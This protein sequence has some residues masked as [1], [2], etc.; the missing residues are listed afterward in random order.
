ML[1]PPPSLC[2]KETAFLHNAYVP[3][4]REG[5]CSQI[6]KLSLRIFEKFMGLQEQGTLP[7]PDTMQN[8]EAQENPSLLLLLTWDRH[9]FKPPFLI[10]RLIRKF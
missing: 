9:C 4:P 1:S 3:F 7:F 6:Y 8:S 10:I 2:S 5:L